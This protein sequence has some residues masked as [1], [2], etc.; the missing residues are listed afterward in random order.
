MKC[1]LSKS[2][3]LSMKCF[4]SKSTFINRFVDEN[5]FEQIN[6]YQQICQRKCW[7]NDK[8]LALPDKI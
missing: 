3:D 1:F 8:N 7:D 6:I 2:T 5:Y 4:L